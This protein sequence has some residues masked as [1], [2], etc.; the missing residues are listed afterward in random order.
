VTLRIAAL[1]ALSLLGACAQ[2]EA[3]VVVLPNFDGSA[4]A[5]TVQDTKGSSAVLLDKPFAAT[6]LRD[7]A[8]KPVAVKPEEARQIFG[9]A[10]NAQPILPV[11][12]TLY[13][14][15]NTDRLTLE[16]EQHVRSV[17]Q[18]IKRRPVH[19]VEVI[20]YTDTVGTQELNQRLSLQRASAIR[21]LLVRE[22]VTASAIST[23]GRGK[24]DQE[25]KTVDQVDEPRNRRVA[26]TVR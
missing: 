7:G 9:A 4:G 2:R 21:D 25:V 1:L 26:I 10:L 6:E 5:V 16:S 13:F 19:Q 14:L 23:A 3:L 15:P 17:L 22:G 18:D 12:F 11:R 24:L 20:G 8:T